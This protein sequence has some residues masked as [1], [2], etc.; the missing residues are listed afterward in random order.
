MHA[1]AATLATGHGEE[2]VECRV[3]VRCAPFSG[4][5]VDDTPQGPPAREA[6]ARA[7]RP[8]FGSGTQ[9]VWRDMPTYAAH[10]EHTGTYNQLVINAQSI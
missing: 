10:D 4:P 5:G 7:K 1:R 2:S 3:L 9:F 6:A 8:P